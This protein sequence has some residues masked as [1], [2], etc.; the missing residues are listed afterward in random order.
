M[1][2]V[3]LC[4]VNETLLDLRVLNPHFA[5][6]FGDASI[7]PQWF[8]QVLRAALVATITDTYHDFGVIAC[9]ALEM[10]AMR[11]NITLTNDDT[12]TILG[13]MRALPPH[14]EVP[15]SLA[16]LKE[17]GLRLAALTNSPPHVLE[18]QMT[19]SGLRDYFEELISVDPTRKYK[20][21]R[22]PYQHAAQTLGVDP[23]NIRMV[24]A[25]DWD[26][27]GAMRAGMA[28]AFIAR[29]G[30]V[31]GPLQALPDIIGEDLREV[32]EK[33]LAAES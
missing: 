32:A 15:E 24:A 13:T 22:E 16:R 19:N 29:P 9:D 10:T 6:I 31:L 27:A 1:P 20:P 8:G 12:V 25:H 26:I 21:A 17:A 5:R 14:P 4:D 7:M 33:I 11:H 18:E 28:G 23:S 2:R 30:M 3:I